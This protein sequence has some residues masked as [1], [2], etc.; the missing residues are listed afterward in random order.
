[1]SEGRGGRR[2]SRKEFVGLGLSSAVMLSS[3]A[4]SPFVAK[5]QTVNFSA[6][7]STKLSRHCRGDGTDETA[8]IQNV[9]N[10]YLHVEADE[11]PGGVAYGVGQANGLALRSG[12]EIDGTGFGKFR[13]VGGYKHQQV[14]FKNNDFVRGN[15]GIKLNNISI[16]GRRQGDMTVPRID[17]KCQTTGIFFKVHDDSPTEKLRNISLTGV[18]VHNWPGI[19]ILVL[20][21]K[22]FHYT[23]VKCVNPAR[24]GMKW[25]A[26]CYDI[27]LLRCVSAQTGDVAIG[28]WATG[29]VYGAPNK[30]IPAGDLH[31]VTLT[32][33]ASSVRTNAQY[34]AALMIYGARQVTARGCTLGP[35]L[36][37]VVHINSDTFTAKEYVPSD[38][39]IEDCTMLGGR[40]NSFE[41]E[42]DR[43]VRIIARNNHMIRPATN[44]VHVRSATRG[45]HNLDVTVTGN[46]L[47]SPG[48]DHILIDD[49]VRGVTLS[50]NE[51]V[52]D[53]ATHPTI[54]N[55]EPA[56][57][58]TVTKARPA[59]KAVVKDNKDGS[60]VTKGKI[61]LHVDGRKIDPRKFKYYPYSGNLT[62]VPP[63]NLRNG[64]HT[65]KVIAED[66][67]GNATSRSWY[68][69]VRA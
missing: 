15:S 11:P 62:Y 60:G 38:I 30:N 1:M 67:A 10:N 58:A 12:Q 65:A 5:A 18:E 52:Y 56:N 59:I 2:I 9:L 6:A 39:L 22:H 54:S 45:R 68:F 21:G 41:V 42:A 3:G 36:N 13:R 57:N 43:A 34:G 48:R 44:C 40:L 63:R 19:G 4:I 7:S 16:E 69:T 66:R 33:C 32:N 53:D 31:H 64:K 27:N 55:L 23:D 35:A 51:L 20:N 28:L 47:Q 14:C 61:T 50:N 46:T 8:K 37:D 17:S 26:D 49:N 24:G 25:T 29:F